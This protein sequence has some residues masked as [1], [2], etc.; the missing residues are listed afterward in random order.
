MDTS[1]TKTQD[2]F[3]IGAVAREI[4][5][6]PEVLRTWEARYG[7]PVAVRTESGHRRFRS[8]DVDLLR[9]VI[10]AKE[11]GAP[12]DSAIREVL[13]RDSLADVDS[14]YAVVTRR[15]PDLPVQALRRDT[16]IAL[17]HA[18]ED[19]CLAQATR[20]LVLGAFQEQVHLERA[21]PRWGELART[22]TWCAALA[23]LETTPPAAPR[24]A[25]VALG[26]Q[27][28]M[29]REWT[30]VCYSRDFAATLAAWEVPGQ[31]R[32]GP[33]RRYEAVL[34]TSPRVARTAAEA[35]LSVAAHHDVAA[36]AA[37]VELVRA[38]P[39]RAPG[40]PADRLWT[41]AIGYLDERL[42][43]R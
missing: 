9:Q 16:L 27:D 35:L 18:M 19:E 32:S 4:G 38:E 6:R 13:S 12:L 10:A 36:P 42:P 22:A 34:S 1:T 30:L 41:R 31:D 37:A 29:L 20:P 24:I 25:T 23:A 5:V 3:P 33:A 11:G 7:F 28:R 26:E 14:A 21:L 8:G 40:A 17:S 2:L 43:P 15:F 39:S